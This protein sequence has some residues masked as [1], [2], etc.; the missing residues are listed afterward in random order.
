MSETQSD[1]F[2]WQAFFQHAVQ[3][4]FLLNRRR[5]ILFV[6][7]AWEICTGLTLAEVRGR[8]CRRRPA[9]AAAEKEEAILG[10]CAPPADALDG[11][12]CQVRRRAP[13]SADWWEIQFLPFAGAKELLGVL[14]AIRVLSAPADA[15][16]ALPEKLMALRDR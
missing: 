2:R 9:S 10:I 13:G 5:R 15:P 1:A 7:R 6:N 12:T 4:L 14:G 3:P 11:R 16:P 8:V